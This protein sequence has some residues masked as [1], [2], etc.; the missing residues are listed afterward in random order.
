MG[1]PR[2]D[3]EARIASD[4]RTPTSAISLDQSQFDLSSATSA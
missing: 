2:L 3:F 4:A 1:T